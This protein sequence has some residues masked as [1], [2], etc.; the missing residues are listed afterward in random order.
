MSLQIIR[1]GLLTTVQDAGRCGFQ[2]YGVVVGGA[3]D[4]YAY[5]VANLL[6]GNT[7]G[8]AVLE[9]TVKGPIIKFLDDRLIA[10][11]GGD[12]AAQINGAMLPAG[13]PVFVRAGSELN[14]GS[15]RQGCRGYLAVAG[16]IAVTPVLGS[17]STY[18]RAGLGGLDGC[19]LQEGDTLQL[20]DPSA[21]ALHYMVQLA[22]LAGAGKFAAPRWFAYRG[23]LLERT[24]VNEIRAMRGRHLAAFTQAS[25]EQFWQTAWRIT[26]QSDRMGYRLSGPK[27]ELTAPLEIISEA[28]TIGTVQ[29]PPEGQP[30]ALLADRPTTGGYPKVAHIAAVDLDLLAQA[31]PGQQVQ[32]EEITLAQA[33][34]LYLAREQELRKLELDVARHMA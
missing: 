12:F 7:G 13:R 4:Q 1:P 16:G 28:V 11:C 5:R 6:V 22:Q 8:A 31:S 9:I 21:M 20:G 29:V 27:L 24:S 3:M 10:L 19:A 14:I 15:C 25:Q 26:P 18:L 32:F 17:R 34:Q 30:I 23:K 2:Q 33:Q